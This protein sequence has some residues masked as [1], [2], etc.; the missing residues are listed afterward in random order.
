[1]PPKL[2]DSNYPSFL[3]D[4]ASSLHRLNTELVYMKLN[5]NTMNKEEFL[6]VLAAAKTQAD[7]LDACIKTAKQLK[8]EDS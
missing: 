6:K 8:Y 3:D 2:N 1:M 5:V 7:A 4:L